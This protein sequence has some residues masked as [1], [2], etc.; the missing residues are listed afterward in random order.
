[1]LKKFYLAC[2]GW[3]LMMLLLEADVT[4]WMSYLDQATTASFQIVFNSSVMLPF[5]AA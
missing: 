2:C 4:D 5:D 3:Q 1:M